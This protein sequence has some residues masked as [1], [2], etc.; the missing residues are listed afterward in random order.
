MAFKDFPG[1]FP[2]IFKD[3]KDKTEQITPKFRCM[4]RIIDESGNTNKSLKFFWIVALP[5]ASRQ[6]AIKYIL[7][8]FTDIRT[9]IKAFGGL[10]GAFKV[11][12]C[13]RRVIYKKRLFVFCG[14]ECNGTE[15]DPL[16]TRLFASP[17]SVPQNTD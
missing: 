12:K 16:G 2:T 15:Q 1:L 10:V 17:C 9:S 3:F 6:K 7:K 4:C 13:I 14:T 5:Y 8:G 11:V